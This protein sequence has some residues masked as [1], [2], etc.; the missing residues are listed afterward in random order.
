MAFVTLLSLQTLSWC[1][2]RSPCYSEKHKGVGTTRTL[3][4]LHS[5][6]RHYPM[7]TGHSSR[8]HKYAPQ[9]SSTQENPSR[10]WEPHPPE[11]ETHGQTGNAG[12]LHHFS[13]PLFLN[14]S[15]GTN[16]D[17]GLIRTVEHFGKVLHRCQLSSLIFLQ[18]RCT[19]Q[20][21]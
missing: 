2:S 18:P 15:N 19:E 8:N 5:F 13:A 14:V 16:N 9:S 10:A 6:Q 12:N 20:Y 4:F 21:S 7:A 11:L 17:G 1:T 3:R